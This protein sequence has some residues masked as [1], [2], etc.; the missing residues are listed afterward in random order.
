MNCSYIVAALL[1]AL[2]VLAAD[3][4]KL[5]IYDL[6][7]SHTSVVFKVSHLGFSHTWGMIPK[8]EGK[9]QISETKPELTNVE[10]KLNLDSVQTFDSKRDE[11][12]KN[13]DFFDVKK[14]PHLTFKSKAVKKMSDSDYEVTGTLSFHGAK[15]DITFPL[16]RNRTGNDPWGKFRTGGDA[17]FVVK[18]SDFGMK[19]MTGPNEVGDEITMNVSFEGIRR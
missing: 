2:P 7:P 16:K 14:F 10:L 6:D 8:V 9:F 17:Q 3:K 12:I 4:D 13:S 15:K 11:H 5:D 19:Y 1:L 18:R